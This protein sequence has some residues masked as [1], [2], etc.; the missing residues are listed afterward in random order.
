MTLKTLGLLTLMTMC[1]MMI[2]A[3]DESSVAVFDRILVDIGDEQ[4]IE[5]SLSTFSAPHDEYNRDIQGVRR[6]KSCAAR[7]AGRRHRPNRGSRS[8]HGDHRRNAPSGARVAATTHYPELKAYALETA[9]VE[10]ACCEFDVNTL[11][12]TYRLLIGLPGKSNAFA[13]LSHLGMSESVINEAKGLI[14]GETRRFEQ[15]VE[16][17][18][19]SHAGL[20]S[21]R[22]KARELLSSAKELERKSK[23]RAGKP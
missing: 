15:V 12:P 7:R 4:S 5:Q 9:G 6:K 2:P 13:I 21:E 11:S 3:A 17:L 14:S 16:T 19:Q 23:A 18:Q 1:G 22:A 20:E 8:C 10:N